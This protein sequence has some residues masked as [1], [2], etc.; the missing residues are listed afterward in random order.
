[1]I[2]EPVSG[3]VYVCTWLL[4]C[5][6]MYSM[7]LSPDYLQITDGE[8][9]VSRL[10]FLLDLILIDLPAT[11]PHSWQGMMIQMEDCFLVL[12]YLGFPPENSLCSIQGVVNVRA[13]MRPKV[14]EEKWISR[15]TRAGV[16]DS[17]MDSLPCGN[18]L[19]AATWFDKS[20]TDIQGTRSMCL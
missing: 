12:V 15:V 7:L 10:Y 19:W 9:W 2:L 6:H 11:P 16:K 3:H 18:M 20:S 17:T 5:L 1:M 14:W 4:H 8:Q 13:L